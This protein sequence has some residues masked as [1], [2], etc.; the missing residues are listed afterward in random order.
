MDKEK[1]K[2]LKVFKSTAKLPKSIL[3]MK[4]GIIIKSKPKLN[5]K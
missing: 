3:K 5:I 1:L 2:N 4:A